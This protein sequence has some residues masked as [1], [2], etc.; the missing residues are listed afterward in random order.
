MDTV[1]KGIAMLSMCKTGV[2]DVHNWKIRRSTA[3]LE[4]QGVMRSDL[5]FCSHEQQLFLGRSMRGLT[6]MSQEGRSRYAACFV[7]CEL[8]VPSVKLHTFLWPPLAGAF[9]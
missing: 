7:M 8:G 9:Q 1:V 6:E 4:Q 5:A 2:L 3:Q